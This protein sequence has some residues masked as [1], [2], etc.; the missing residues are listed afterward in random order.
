MATAF[1][2]LGYGITL[3]LM[4]LLTVTLPLGSEADKYTQEA[5]H[6]VITGIQGFR[7]TVW[8]CH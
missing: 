8:V 3:P 5:L 6:T 2:P 1:T 7:S 4:T